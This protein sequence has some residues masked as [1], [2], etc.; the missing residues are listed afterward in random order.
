MN[1]K[2]RIYFLFLFFTGIQFLS[3]QNDID[4]DK[5]FKYAINLYQSGE[6]DHALSVFKKISIELPYNQK[7]TAAYIFVGKT[8]LQMNDL[9]SATQYLQDF[10]E[11]YPESE[12]K[13][14]AQLSL[15]KVFY[16]RKDYEKAF[17]N[18]LDLVASS[19]QSEYKKYSSSLGEKIAVNYIELNQ[20]KN[21][22]DNPSLSSLKPY[23]L[24]LIGEKEQSE[25]NFSD[26]SKT[27]KELINKY[28]DS[29]PADKAEKLISK[30]GNKNKEA[31]SEN[32]LAVLLPLHNIANG[33]KIASAGEILEGIKYAISE[34][35]QENETQVGLV[36][37]DTGNDSTTISQISDEISSLPSIKAIIGPI[38]SNEVRYTLEDFK[39]SGI[40]V[41]SP[42]ATDNDLTKLSEYFFQA[43]PSFSMRGKVIAQYA[44]YVAGKRNMA[45]MSAQQGYSVLLA[46]AFINEFKN[47]GGNII[48]N[49]KYNDGSYDLNQS[50][51][52]I[53][54]NTDNL[55]GIYLPLSNKMNAAP[56][57]SQMVQ[58]Q[59]NIPLF[60][61]Q[62]WFFAKGFETSSELS[63]Q[64]SFTS[65]FFLDYN[66]SSFISFSKDFVQ[67]TGFD[68]NRNV[69]YGYDTAIYLLNLISNGAD[70]RSS[71]IN[72]MESGIEVKGYHNF[73][74]FGKEHINK[75]LN[76]IRYKDGKF[77]LV[78][79]FKSGE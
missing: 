69:L 43:N 15:V 74:A 20:L 45:V 1:N 21:Y 62:D 66:D 77:E 14:E 73:I 57:L 28:P 56:L 63:N 6:Y 65:D 13:V 38:F 7:T 30:I 79:H 12:Y 70:S 41:I 27:F 8:Y 44:Y 61:N 40:P 19:N 33:E 9:S 47:I 25:N 42:T 39:Y 37:R 35:N 29:D 72:V 75:F 76:I 55:D 67:K 26:A 17:E 4:V 51:S 78:D 32:L 48:V 52:A 54:S 64:L 24:L 71:L 50:L 22:Y 16:L 34:Y 2:T 49:S 58:Q 68:I 31:A 46:D 3:A 5:Q 59:I 53:A 18:V 11:Q 36:I 23:L 10:L 60:G